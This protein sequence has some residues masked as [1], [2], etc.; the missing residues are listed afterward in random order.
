[1]TDFTDPAVGTRDDAVAYQFLDTLAYVRVSGTQTDSRQ[2]VVE[3]HY[4]EGHA[5][6][7][8]IH[9]ET[10]ETIHI[11]DGT[12]TVH[13][14]DGLRSVTAG[15]TVVLPRGQQHALVADEQ[16]VVLASTTPAGFDEFVTGVGKPTDSEMI[17]TEPPPEAMVE[18]VN[19]LAAEHDIKIVGP[20]PNEQ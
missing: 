4:R 3:L 7:E 20:P 19:E 15:A 14:A 17:P 12:V 11:L 2:S 5:T 8:H 1:M 10:D 18:R 6:P 13:T 9:T 16:S